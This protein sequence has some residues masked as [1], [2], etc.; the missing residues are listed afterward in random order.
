MFLSDMMFSEELLDNRQTLNSVKKKDW[1]QVWRVGSKICLDSS[2]NS[3]FWAG[4]TGYIFVLWANTE[5][6][7]LT[8]FFFFVVQFLLCSTAF[9]SLCIGIFMHSSLSLS[10]SF[11]LSLF[12]F[13]A[14]F[15]SL[16]LLWYFHLSLILLAFLPVFLT[17]TSIKK[18]NKTDV[19]LLM[20]LVPS[21]RQF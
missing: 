14:S 13:T 20:S 7:F 8:V 4:S 3:A 15:F 11:S 18:D 9:F 2:R 12:P 16:C 5:R 21:D 6:A 10:L 17:H 19:N 1:A